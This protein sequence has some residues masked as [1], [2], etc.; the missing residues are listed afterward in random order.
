MSAVTSPIG[1]EV[2]DEPS[3]PPDLVRATLSD[4][5]RANMLFGGRAAV[6]F[7]VKRLLTGRRG[8][9][10]VLDI[11]AGGGDIALFVAR[12]ARKLGTTLEPL[13]LDRHPAAAVLCRQRGLPTV[14]ADACALPL[15]PGSV[16]IVVASQVLHHFSRDGA[17]ELLRAFA[18][19]ARVGIVI[20]DLRRA[21]AAAMGIWLASLALGFH[22]ITRRDGVTSVRRGFAP[23]E[24]ADLM[25]AA[26]LDATVHRR[27]GYRLV[28]AS[29]APYAHS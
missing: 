13:A 12:Q 11:G 7:G 26:G 17:I 6:W 4:I 23:N 8:R 21:P 3:C 14:V 27:P 18:P 9:L 1:S 15:S 20:A 2:L 24:L 28:A 19:L 22:P 10:T 25:A 5:A 16:D 29:R